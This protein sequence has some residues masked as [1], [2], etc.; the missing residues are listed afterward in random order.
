MTAARFSAIRYLYKSVSERLNVI[1]HHMTKYKEVGAF[2]FCN[3]LLSDFCTRSTGQS[4]RSPL[5]L[6]QTDTP[7]P[8]NLHVHD[9]FYVVVS[10]FNN[11]WKEM[12]FSNRSIASCCSESF[13]SKNQSPRWQATYFHRQFRMP[14]APS[15]LV[16]FDGDK[17]GLV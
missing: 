6:C 7:S 2:I 17:P 5:F 8:D 3:S 11:M 12:E 10:D 14:Q 15:L 1:K 4:N 16:A 13:K 9:I